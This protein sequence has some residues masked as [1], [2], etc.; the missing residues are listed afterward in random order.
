MGCIE[1]KMVDVLSNHL[2]EGIDSP[3]LGAIGCV[4]V[5]PNTLDI[6][7]IDVLVDVGILGRLVHGA[8]MV[9]A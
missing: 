1:L 3:E 9:V 4:S 5:G 6:V 8:E 2:E 7:E